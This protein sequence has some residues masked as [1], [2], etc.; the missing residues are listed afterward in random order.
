MEEQEK[1]VSISPEGN[2]K[3]SNVVGKNIISENK[4][5]PSA[6]IGSVNS[7]LGVKSNVPSTSSVVRTY[8]GDLASVM[9]EKRGSV[10]KIA[11]SEQIKKDLKTFSTQT[12]THSKTNLIILSIAGILFL[13]GISFLIFSYL[14]KKPETITEQIINNATS[15][16]SSENQKEIATIGL[17]Q[18]KLIK[19]V[20]DE[21]RT[22]NIRLDTLEEI[23][24]T[25]EIGGTKQKI[26]T[27]K[28]FQILGSR[29]PS[30]LLRSLDKNFMLG[31]HAFNG[32]QAF[33]ILKT[34]FYENA[35]LGLLKW[36]NDMPGELLSLLGVNINADN[37][38]LLDKEFTDTTFK[39]RDARAL[40]D[41]NG[42]P[43]LIYSM[44][45]RDTIIITTGEDT[46]NEVI[47]KLNAPKSLNQ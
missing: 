34:D 44:P 23:Y 30:V 24:L 5:N 1:I 20:G 35:F 27:E 4:P 25:E 8:E 16:I 12:T 28:F 43:V 7:I 14:N 32:N 40:F 31:I 22:S 29:I 2:I 46:L 13:S 37:R 15:I 45:Q 17:S 21:V 9:K 38:Y 39:N 36:E 11:V 47:N 42:N 6:L 26:S 19:A 18:S 10:I 3:E 41:N 33:L